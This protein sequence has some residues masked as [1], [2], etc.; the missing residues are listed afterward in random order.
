MRI[1][2][3]LIAPIIQHCWGA[4]ISE[5]L[6]HKCTTFNYILKNAF[7]APP[8]GDNSEIANLCGT[9]EVKIYKWGDIEYNDANRQYFRT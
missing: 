3:Q 6:Y 4:T 7:F 9:K 5:T 8:D 2:A 1:F